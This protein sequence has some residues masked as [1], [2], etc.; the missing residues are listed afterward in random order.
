M[1]NSSSHDENSSASASSPSSAAETSQDTIAYLPPNLALNLEAFGK[2]LRERR[3]MAQ[4]SQAKLSKLIGLTEMTLRNIENAHNPPSESS[5]R[6]LLELSELNLSVS[7][8]P[9][10]HR[11]NL[12]EDLEFYRH[13]HWF[14]A[15]DYEI[16]KLWVEFRKQLNSE[17]GLIE[18]TYLYLDA[19]SSTDYVNMSDESEFFLRRNAPMLEIAREAMQLVD[20]NNMDVIALGPG[21]GQLETR[22]TQSLMLIRP[23]LRVRFHLLD[24]SQPLLNVS[25]RH[26]TDTLSQYQ[27][28]FVAGMLGNFYGLPNYQ[29]LFYIPP[30]RPTGRIFAIL[31]GTLSNIDNEIRFVRHSLAIASVGDLLVISLQRSEAAA[32][33]EE[34][35]RKSDPAFRKPFPKLH[36]R[37]LGGPIRRYCENVTDVSFNLTVRLDCVIPESYALDAVANV[38][39]KDGRTRKISMCRFKRYN[40]ESLSARLA[41]EGWVLRQTFPAKFTDDGDESFFLFQKIALPEQPPMRTEDTRPG[42]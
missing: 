40:V 6:R 19:E 28:V 13:L 30:T 31:G 25:Y 16:L 7:D 1:R 8:L 33:T 20:Y 4:L 12:E 38:K 5:L 15:P 37:W 22:L 2:L 29:H 35:I 36:A 42:K 21:S 41:I 14:I 17:G 24:I 3:Q 23:D 10:I 18:Q 11:Y 32:L 26:A 34:A 27:S 39:F 9:T